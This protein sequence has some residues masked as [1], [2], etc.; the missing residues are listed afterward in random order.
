[1]AIQTRAS[2]YGNARASFR[3]SNT[4]KLRRSQDANKG[5]GSNFCHSVLLLK[6]YISACL[7][8][9]G[10]DVPASEVHEFSHQDRRLE[11]ATK[12]IVW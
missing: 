8:N 3:V 6:I 4:G 5:K 7:P 1:M 2:N 10:Y 11:L 12:F 9:R